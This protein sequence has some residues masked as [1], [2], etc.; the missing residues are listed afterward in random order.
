MPTAEQHVAGISVLV[1]GSELSQELRNLLVEVRVRD[2]MALPDAAT[3]RI[4]DADGENVDALMG[5]FNI[6]KKVEIKAGAAGTA[7]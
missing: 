1:D 2:T 4:T 3:V 6:G 5:K 7:R